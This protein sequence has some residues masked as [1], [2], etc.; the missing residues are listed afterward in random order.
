MVADTITTM[1]E[2]ITAEAEEDTI[3]ITVVEADSREEQTIPNNLL[4]NPKD[5]QTKV[6]LNTPDLKPQLQSR[7]I[8]KEVEILRAPPA[9]EEN[10][11]ITEIEDRIIEKKKRI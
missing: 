1:A 5:S 11:E 8:T 2:A 3:I 9:E 7:E 6:D 4:P 10:T